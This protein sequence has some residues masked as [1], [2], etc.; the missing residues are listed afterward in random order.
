[1]QA[2]LLSPLLACRSVRKFKILSEF[3]LKKEA[4]DLRA[5]QLETVLT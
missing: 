5:V 1:M 3:K 2:K 4:L